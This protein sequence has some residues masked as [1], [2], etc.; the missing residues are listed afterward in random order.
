MFTG[1]KP[2]GNVV[3]EHLQGGAGDG[4]QRAAQ[5]QEQGAEGGRGRH[6]PEDRRDPGGRVDPEL[7]PEPVST[8]DR[9]TAFDAQKTLDTDPNKPLR[10][11]AFSERYPPGSTFKVVTAA[12]MLENGETPTER[13]AG[14]PAVRAAADRWLLHQERQPEHLPRADHHADPGAHR[15]VQHGV[16]PVRRRE[17]RRRQDPRHGEE[18][19]VRVRR[20]TIDRDE[21][22]T[23]FLV[24]ESTVG[25]MTDAPGKVD[26][27]ATRPVVDR[28][29]RGGR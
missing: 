7:R 12:A 2:G 20:P 4:V 5:Q 29:A 22:N 26:P 27:A 18:V 25:S 17:A 10:N 15:V 21:K 3:H 11:R 8:H 13:A 9:T 24:A 23:C 16:R 14:R 19:R 1:D 6:R 28:P